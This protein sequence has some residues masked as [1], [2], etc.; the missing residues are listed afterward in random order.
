MQPIEVKI[1]KIKA[2][3][4]PLKVWGPRRSIPCSPPPLGRPGDEQ[5]YTILYSL[6]TSTIEELL[7]F[8]EY[9]GVCK[10]GGDLYR[11]AFGAMYIYVD[12]HE[13]RNSGSVTHCNKAWVQGYFI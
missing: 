12:N 2:S 6:G 13:V 5:S 7:H 1:R 4:G 9:C 3:W 8:M 10:S 11:Q